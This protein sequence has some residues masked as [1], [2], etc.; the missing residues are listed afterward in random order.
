MSHTWQIFQK[1]VMI[2]QYKSN[3]WKFVFLFQ[4]HP[5]HELK[6]WFLLRRMVFFWNL[7]SKTHILSCIAKLSHTWRCF[8]ANFFSL[9]N[10]YSKSHVDVLLPSIHHKKW[11]SCNF[12]SLLVLEKITFEVLLSHTWQVSHMWQKPLPKKFILLKIVF[13][14]LEIIKLIQIKI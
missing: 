2:L 3:K 14:D 8:N 5:L 1:P 6:L 12:Y 13:V 10:S 9:C 7:T 4:N 11:A